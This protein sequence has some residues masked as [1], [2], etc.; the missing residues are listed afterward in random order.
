MQRPLDCRALHEVDTREIISFRSA[1][2]V[3]ILLVVDGVARC[4]RSGRYALANCLS[5]SM[6]LGSANIGGL[7]VS[8]TT[9][10]EFNC[11]QHT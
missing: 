11:L 9:E 7:V 3:V 6:V 5:V 8:V 4:R 10:R 1:G 2:I